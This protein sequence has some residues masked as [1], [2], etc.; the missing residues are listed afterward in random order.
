MFQV[1]PTCNYKN[2]SGIYR[3][4]AAGDLTLELYLFP[5]IILFTFVLYFIASLMNPG[6]VPIAT[7]EVILLLVTF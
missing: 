6:Y 7:G 3:S 2:Y 5:V 4:V 1:A